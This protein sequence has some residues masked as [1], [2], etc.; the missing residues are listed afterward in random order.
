MTRYTK[1]DV[2][3]AYARF[4]AA[5]SDTGADTSRAYLQI[6]SPGDGKTRYLIG[7]IPGSTGRTFLGAREA[8]DALHFA[9]DVLYAASLAHQPARPSPVYGLN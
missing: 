5:L 6:S 2:E 1:T 3:K 4:I 7:N 9:S 8:W